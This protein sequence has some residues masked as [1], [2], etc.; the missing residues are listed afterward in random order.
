MARI[1]PVDPAHADERTAAT[2][3]AVAKKLGALPN[4]FT[5]FA[6][7]PAALSGYLGL[8]EQLAGGRL[9]P[10]QR[11]LIA[12]AVAEENA[13]DYCLAAHAA[14]GRA[15]GL[16]DDDIERARAAGARDAVDQRVTLFALKVARSRAALSDD[17]FHAAREAGLDDGLIVEIVAN[18]ALNVMTN[19]LNRVAATEIDF[20]RL[21]TRRAA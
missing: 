8:A 10:R 2:L 21:A 11:E 15:V 19:Y 13:C 17:E 5:T 14:L 20:P 16:D 9:S 1:N 18:V 4:M 6:H 3:H 12:I 7:S